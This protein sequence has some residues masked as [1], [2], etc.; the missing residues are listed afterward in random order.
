MQSLRSQFFIWLALFLLIANVQQHLGGHMKALKFITSIISVLIFSHYA[1]ALN[2]LRPVNAP[3]KH[4]SIDQQNLTVR[5]VG[6]LPNECSIMPQPT[7]STEGSEGQLLLSVTA[8]Q[9][10]DLCANR[11]GVAFDL[12]FDI[13]SLKFNIEELN[14]DPNASYKIVSKD[15]SASILFDFRDVPFT[16]PYASDVLVGDLQKIESEN[17]Y[18][19]VTSDQVLEVNSPIIDLNNHLGDRVE[20]QG[21]ILNLR[22]AGTSLIKREQTPS[23]FLITGIN[24]TSY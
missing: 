4:I 23:T 16:L 20:V 12:A 10:T 6:E 8:Y 14:L 19:L 18:V 3:I 5:I 24:T 17:K 15:G 2:S 7:L 22:I 13:R 21:H 11:V 9:M 1:H